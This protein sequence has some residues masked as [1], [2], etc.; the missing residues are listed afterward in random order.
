M[1]EGVE[2]RLAQTG[3]LRDFQKSRL[4]SGFEVIDSGL[5]SACHTA[6]RYAPAGRGCDPQWCRTWRS[7]AALPRQIGDF[8]AT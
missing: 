2:D 8:V 1:V 6:A 4:E 5:V 3:L 7:V